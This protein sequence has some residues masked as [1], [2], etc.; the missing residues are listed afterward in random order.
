MKKIFTEI[1]IIVSLAVVAASCQSDDLGRAGNS[2]DNASV[3][4]FPTVSGLSEGL[5]RSGL[6]ETLTISPDGE[7]VSVSEDDPGFCDHMASA[8]R[9]SLVNREGPDAIAFP[10]DRTFFVTAW[11]ST[12]TTA[13]ILWSEVRFIE[14]IQDGHSLK[15]NM[16]NTTDA[17]GN[18]EEHLWY[19]DETK[20]FFAYSNLPEGSGTASVVTDA[21][22]G[23]AAGMNLTYTGPASA[24][25][26]KDLLLGYYCG[27]GDS[28]GD[29][30]QDGTASIHFKHALTSVVFKMG[31]VVGTTSFRV[32]AI[33]IEGLYKSA[34]CLLS[35]EA[36]GFDLDWTPDLSD[37]KPVI[38]TVSQS[39]ASMPEEGGEFGEP[40]I[41]IPQNFTECAARIRFTIEVDGKT[42]DVFHPLSAGSWG[43]GSVNSYTVNYNGHEGIQLWENGPYWATKNV[44]ADKPEDYGWYFAWGETTGYTCKNVHSDPLQPG[45]DAYE[46]D[47][48]S[49]VDGSTRYQGFSIFPGSYVG[50]GNTLSAIPVND[51]Y[52]AAQKNMGAKWRMPTK[53]E[54]EDLI[55]NTTRKYTSRNGV[56]GFLFTG[57]GDYSKR[58]VFI[59]ASGWGEGNAISHRKIEFAALL[60]TSNYCYTV[61]LGFNSY[62][63]ST[64]EQEDR[65]YAGVGSDNVY[66]GR[67]IRAVENTAY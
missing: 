19:K 63:H 46:C 42:L 24:S 66:G 22:T 39:I 32:T 48:C 57:I 56:R 8:T 59:P 54:C 51:T 47:F 62:G 17:S 61:E 25:D 50:P 29:G 26:Q 1:A 9:G 40:F 67:V 10:T 16:W 15:H 31:N 38:M 35:P 5:T 60:W 37:D 12:G 4:F 41:V 2:C 6:G 53:V 34:T 65:D 7:S 14:S 30:K 55:S 23:K 49:V 3:S 33:A 36:D 44:G 18:V 52:D 13:D 21:T 27:K 43:A 20:S 58:T 28:A 45:Q 11:N 64:E